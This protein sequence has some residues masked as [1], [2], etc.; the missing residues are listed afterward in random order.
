MLVS[1]R[2]VRHIEHLVPRA[3]VFFR[4]PVAFHTPVHIQ[5]VDLKCQWHQIDA[6]MAG[7]AANALVYMNAVIEVDVVR[8]VV[9]ASP[10]NRPAAPETRSH[11]L[12]EFSVRPNLSV[13]AHAGFGRR[14]TCEG[15]GF[16]RRMAIAAIYA[17]VGDVML[18]AEGNWLI[19]RYSN[20]GREVTTVDGICSCKEGA[21]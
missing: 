4:L 3:N 16:H 17:I 11:W 1:R 6:P 19:L 8:Q 20:I 13:A 2:L 12:Q 10:C 15:R 7:G 21:D 14:N 18:M 5:C 9:D